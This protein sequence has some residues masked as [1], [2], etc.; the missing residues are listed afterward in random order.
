MP[1]ARRKRGTRTH[2]QNR[3]IAYAE[4]VWA[5][6]P[7]DGSGRPRSLITDDRNGAERRRQRRA[8]GGVLS[9]ESISAARG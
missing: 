3:P 1:A 4:S 9:V 6:R 7:R 8:T 2:V 5:T